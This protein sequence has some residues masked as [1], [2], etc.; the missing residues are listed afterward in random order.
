MGN[1]ICCGVDD[2][3]H[4]NSRVALPRHPRVKGAIKNKS[5]YHIYKPSANPVVTTAASSAF[6]SLTKSANASMQ[7]EV[8]KYIEHQ[9]GQ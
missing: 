6:D 7:D 5:D 2:V 8:F 9:A 3:K 1:D 4:D